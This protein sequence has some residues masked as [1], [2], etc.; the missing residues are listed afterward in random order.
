M[1]PRI[2]ALT[3][4]TELPRAGDHLRVAQRRARH[5]RVFHAGSDA[6]KEQQKDRLTTDWIL[7][8]T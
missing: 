1:I 5:S 6:P 8:E 4:L 7:V 3:E 2:D